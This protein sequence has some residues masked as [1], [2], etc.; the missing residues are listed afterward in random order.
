MKQLSIA[1]LLFAVGVVLLGFAFS[2][3]TYLSVEDTRL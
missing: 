1:K 3:S 2:Q